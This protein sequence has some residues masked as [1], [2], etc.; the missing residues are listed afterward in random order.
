LSITWFVKLHF[1]EVGFYFFLLLWYFT[2]GFD[3]KV[4][5]LMTLVT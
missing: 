2:F 4:N 1:L 3:V 5:L